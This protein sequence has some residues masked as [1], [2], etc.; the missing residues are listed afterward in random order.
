MWSGIHFAR[1]L[2]A[3]TMEESLPGPKLFAFSLNVRLLKMIAPL[4]RP[5]PDDCHRSSTAREPARLPD[6][7][8]ER[9]RPPVHRVR[10]HASQMAGIAEIFLANHK[11]GS[12]AGINAQ[13]AAVLASLALQH[14]FR[15][16]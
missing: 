4:A 9:A 12:M 2:A 1:K 16:M 11:A 15:S 10:S 7:R 8:P 14:G 5:V 3:L 6:L 13:D